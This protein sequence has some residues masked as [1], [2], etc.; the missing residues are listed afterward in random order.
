MGL[1]LGLTFGYRELAADP[2]FARF[3]VCDGS[4]GRPECRL[5]A[6]GAARPAAPSFYF[7]RAGA[8]V[9]VVYFHANATDCGAMLPA[10]AAFS[11][12]LDVAVLAVEYCGYGPA[13][14]SPTV[15]NVEANARAAYAEARRRGFPPSR[16]VLYGQSVGSGPAC[17]IAAREPVRGVALH[18]PIASG[19]RALTGGGA[20]SPVRVYACLDPFNNLREVRRIRAPLVVF[21]GTHDEEIPVAHGRLLHEA[22]Q[23][24]RDPFWVER[25]GHNNLLEVAGDAYFERLAAFLASLDADAK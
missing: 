12:R 16:I 14:G 24:S 21:H 2:A 1:E 10:Y 3:A 25:A 6:D 4:D 13:A 18:S 23:D 22:A 20:C 5:L 8:A 17:Y 15:R 9:I 11:A 7:A 19:I